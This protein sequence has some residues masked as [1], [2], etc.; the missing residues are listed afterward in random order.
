MNTNE[1]VVDRQVDEDGREW[2]VVRFPLDQVLGASSSGQNVIVAKIV[3]PQG[4]PGSQVKVS[5]FTA[6]RQALTPDE[7]R[8]CNEA[9]TSEKGLA[10]A[11]RKAERKLARQAATQGTAVGNVQTA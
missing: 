10:A 1:I 3:S 4:I 9:Q 7:A 6:Y 11:K 5:G 2:G 8:M